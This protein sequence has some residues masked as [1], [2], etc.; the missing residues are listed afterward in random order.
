MIPAEWEVFECEGSLAD[1]YSRVRARSHLTLHRGENMAPEKNP[2]TTTLPTS[3]I[4]ELANVLV[5]LKSLRTQGSKITSKS[6]SSNFERFISESRRVL[7]DSAS[8]IPRGNRFSSDEIDEEIK[9][10]RAAIRHKIS[11]IERQLPVGRVRSRK[12]GRKRTQ[13]TNRGK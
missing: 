12:V 7:G 6:T 11:A 13:S 4:E 5:Q 9:L 3:A 1:P 2:N 10:L 8:S